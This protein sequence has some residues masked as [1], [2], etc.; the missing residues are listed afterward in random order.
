MATA[1]HADVVDDLR[2]ALVEVEADRIAVAKPRA[3]ELRFAGHGHGRPI[4]GHPWRSEL[5]TPCVLHA[6]FVER[7]TAD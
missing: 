5:M 7:R 2:D 4:D 3:A 6:Q 1:N